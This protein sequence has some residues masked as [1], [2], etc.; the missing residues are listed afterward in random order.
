MRVPAVGSRIIRAR[1]H[2]ARLDEDGFAHYY[3]YC[4][5]DVIRDTA[6]LNVD[7]GLHV[8]RRGRSTNSGMSS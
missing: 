7:S 8:L 4:S 2:P 3:A 1:H 5:E 6:P